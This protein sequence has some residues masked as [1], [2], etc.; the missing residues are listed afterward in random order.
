MTPQQFDAFMND[1]RTLMMPV[2]KAAE[3]IV[4]NEARRLL[5][6][7]RGSHARPPLRQRPNRVRLMPGAAVLHR[8]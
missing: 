1:L 4:A 3:I 8:I 6:E 5:P 2:V 7:V